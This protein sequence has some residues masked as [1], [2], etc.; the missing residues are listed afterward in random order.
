MSH[1]TRDNAASRVRSTELTGQERCEL[2]ADDRR[3]LTMSVLAGRTAP[4][5][6]DERAADVAGRETPSNRATEDVLERVTVALHHVH[7]PKLSEAGVIDYEAERQR[8]TP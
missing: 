2:L 6:L 1:T 7:L 8:V 3:R 4:L 5:Q